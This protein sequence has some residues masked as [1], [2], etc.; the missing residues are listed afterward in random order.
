MA[1]FWDQFTDDEAN[2]SLD[3]IYG[4]IPDSMQGIFRN[5]VLASDNYFLFSDA[6]KEVIAEHFVE[7]FIDGGGGIRPDQDAWLAD[8]GM[9]HDEFDWGGWAELYDSIHG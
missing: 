8:L 7:Y 9:D 6:D 5:T 1:G 3:V 4:D 2:Y